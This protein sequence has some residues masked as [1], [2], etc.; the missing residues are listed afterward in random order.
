MNRQL[1]QPHDAAG[2]GAFAFGGVLMVSMARSR[3]ANRPL[4]RAIAAS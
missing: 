3:A 4:K 1:H 2:F